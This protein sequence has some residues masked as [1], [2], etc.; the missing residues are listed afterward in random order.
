MEFEVATVEGNTR[1]AWTD[2]DDLGA[3]RAYGLINGEA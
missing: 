3:C 2:L 1:E